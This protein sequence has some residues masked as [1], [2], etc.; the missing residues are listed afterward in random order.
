M[1]H[2]VLDL[3]R[4]GH[5]V[6]GAQTLHARRDVGHVAQRQPEKDEEERQKQNQ[7]QEKQGSRLGA[8]A[9]AHGADRDATE[10][11]A[12]ADASV[13]STRVSMWIGP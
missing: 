3:R 6:H 2:R 4:D 8:V 7:K 11:H 5:A 13:R 12:E 10:V 1:P 9:T